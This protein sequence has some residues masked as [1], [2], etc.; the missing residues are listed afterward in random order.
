M[1]KEGELIG[2][3]VRNAPADL[4]RTVDDLRGRL[5]GRPI[6]EMI[7]T[8]R[9]L[10]DSYRGQDGIAESMEVAA[11]VLEDGKSSIYSL[12]HPFYRILQEGRTRESMRSALHDIAAGDVIGGTVGGVVGAVGG[13]VTAVGGAVGGAAGGSAGVVIGYLLDWF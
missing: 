7:S 8:L 6:D 10:K 12:D 1:L 3:E 13:P 9:S 4:Q 2:D 5:A 11:H